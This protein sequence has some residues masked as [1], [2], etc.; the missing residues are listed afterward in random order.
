MLRIL[1]GVGCGRLSVLGLFPACIR[2]H[3]FLV[4]LA[5][6]GELPCVDGTWLWVRPQCKVVAH[7]VG[8][9]PR[10]ERHL[11][12]RLPSILGW[13][14][15][16]V[17]IHVASMLTPDMIP[18]HSDVLVWVLQEPIVCLTVCECD[19]PAPAFLVWHQGDGQW[20][21][22]RSVSH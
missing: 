8:Q 7:K 22:Q 5:C 4:E 18:V 2:V 15:L 9:K 1:K 12:L 11:R 13:H 20:V 16:T 21:L 3:G 19:D 17:A 14:C 10:F 6:F